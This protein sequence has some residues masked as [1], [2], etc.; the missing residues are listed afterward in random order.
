MNRE[1]LR[2]DLV[3][4][5]ETFQHNAYTNVFM[6]EIVINEVYCFVYVAVCRT[7]LPAEYGCFAPIKY[8]G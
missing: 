6:F 8:S 2:G 7:E 1:C 4:N 5:T 3:L